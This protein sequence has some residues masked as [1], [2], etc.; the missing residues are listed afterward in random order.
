MANFQKLGVFE[1]HTDTIMDIVWKDQQ[2]FA[3]A[4]AD[5]NVGLCSISGAYTVLQGHQE[6]VNAVAYNISGSILASASSD[7]T[8]RL[9]R[10]TGEVSVLRGH[11]S[12]VSALEWLPNSDTTLVSGS[13]DGCLRI[14]DAIQ[15]TC[16][17]VI[18]HHEDG[19]YSLSISPS[20][21]FV[22]SGSKDQRIVV[23]RIDDGTMVVTFSGNSDVYDVAWDSSGRYVAAAF[24][25]STVT[26]IPVYRY[27]P[28]LS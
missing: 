26:V 13:M 6:H 20:G 4:S 5:F 7:S 3:T 19:I 15:A 16:T 14:W 21:E 8:L 17:Q 12:G 22:A 10:D 1:F 2:N 25:D 28:C 23:A 11:E 18:R 9:W 24:E 27:C